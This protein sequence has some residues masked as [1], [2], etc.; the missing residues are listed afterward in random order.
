MTQQDPIPTIALLEPQRILLDSIAEALKA[1]GNFHVTRLF[2]R[3]DR[4]PHYLSQEPPDLLIMEIQLPEADGLSLL[5]R[6]KERWPDLNILVL[7]SMPES[8][9]S[10]RSLYFG[11]SGYL[12]KSEGITKLIQ[13][14]H[15]I[16]SGDLYMSRLAK[17]MLVG[18]T[19]TG[20]AGPDNP[21]DPLSNR[22]LQVLALVGEGLANAEIAEHLKI[23]PKT[24][25][26]HKGR[27]KEKL[28]LRSAGELTKAGVRLVESKTG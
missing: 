28:S 7:S 13:A 25:D 15:V 8:L 2:T 24:V 11:A 17:R 12:M 5:E 9:F 6:W 23:S 21:L 27:I 16:L 3:P 19:G 1:R 14:I 20:K 18:Q 26:T 22:E 4:V 10:G